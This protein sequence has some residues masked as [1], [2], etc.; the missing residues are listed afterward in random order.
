MKTPHVGNERQIR[1]SFLDSR[2]QASPLPLCP[3]HL[4]SLV[5]L[6]SHFTPGAALFLTILLTACPLQHPLCSPAQAPMGS[7][8][9][10]HISSLS[11]LSPLWSFSTVFALCQ[12]CPSYPNPA[13]WLKALCSRNIFYC[14]GPSHWALF[15]R[16]F[17]ALTS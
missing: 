17:S 5:F 3:A 9:I 12:E 1:T 7:S 6:G 11:S 16:T 13:P 14:S 4:V 15:P 2:S 10:S 8:A